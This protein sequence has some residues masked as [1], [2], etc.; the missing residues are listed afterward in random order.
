MLTNCALISIN[1]TKVAVDWNEFIHRKFHFCSQNVYPYESPFSL[2][3]AVQFSLKALKMNACW[4]GS[5][6]RLKEVIEKLKQYFGSEQKKIEPV[7]SDET[8]SD[9]VIKELISG[10]KKKKSN[11]ALWESKCDYHPAASTIEGF[12]PFHPTAKF[13]FISLTC[14]P[15]PK[16]NIFF[17]VRCHEDGK[18]YPVLC[19]LSQEINSQNIVT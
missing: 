4:I 18:K 9:V 8:L 19:D 16:M 7:Y 12:S 1:A 14:T 3:R 6:E 10:D 15:G 5:Y 11:I 13:V 2:I 17:E